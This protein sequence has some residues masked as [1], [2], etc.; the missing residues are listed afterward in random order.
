M[1]RLLNYV[2]SLFTI[3]VDTYLVDTLSKLNPMQY[4]KLE[5]KAFTTQGVVVEEEEDCFV[6]MYIKGTNEIE[7]IFYDKDKRE[8]ITVD[9]I[10]SCSKFNLTESSLV[11]E[12]IIS[13]LSVGMV[14]TA[15]LLRTRE[16]EDKRLLECISMPLE[17]LALFAKKEC[18]NLVN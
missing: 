4:A 8:I 14:G 3:P 5:D 7:Y 12:V 1:K 18:T 13:M 11:H 17:K 9:D 16:D 6:V 2:K 15:C 10:D